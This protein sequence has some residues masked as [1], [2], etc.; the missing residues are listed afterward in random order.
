MEQEREEP[1]LVSGNKVT[2]LFVSTQDFLHS[3][4]RAPTRTNK[5]TNGLVVIVVPLLRCI[6]HILSSIVQGSAQK[7]GSQ[8]RI[9]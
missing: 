1:G 7:S 5:T 6:P 2:T 9:V 8:E 3:L 4:T